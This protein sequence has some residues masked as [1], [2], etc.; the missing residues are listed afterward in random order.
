[1]FELNSSY[2]LI[3]NAFL[4]QKLL[5]GQR[6]EPIGSRFGANLV[7]GD[8]RTSR[9]INPPWAESSSHLG[10]VAEQEYMK[11]IILL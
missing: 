11:Y 8:V 1:M 7:S 3:W 6:M 5:F 4:M 2:P 9:P 10:F